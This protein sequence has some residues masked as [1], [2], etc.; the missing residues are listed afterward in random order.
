MM[1]GTSRAFALLRRCLALLPLLV[2]A[3]LLCVA[4]VEAE[5]PAVPAPSLPP[6]LS[7]E[8]PPGWDLLPGLSAKIAETS[9]QTAY[10]GEEP[11]SGGAMAYGRANRGALYFTWVDGQSAHPSPESA[12]RG[13]F[14]GV[15]ESPFLATSDAG[16]TQ[17]VLYRER[18]FDGV[19]ELNF[20]WAHMNNDTVNVV[21][22]LGWKSDDGRVHLAIA[23]CVLHNES[24]GEFR[25]LCEAALASL[26]LTKEVKH[27]PL[28]S[29]AAPKLIGK[30]GAE[31]MKVPK[32]QS[33]E[34][35]SSPSIN[36]APAQMGEVLYRGP[37][38]ATSQDKSN[39][40]L[41]GIGVL[42]LAAAFWLTTRSKPGDSSVASE[43]EHG[44]AEDTSANAE[45]AGADEDTGEDDHEDE[46]KADQEKAE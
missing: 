18:N 11:A 2:I 30:L 43:G 39:R 1:R 25:P 46:Q 6:Q 5:Q 7:L 9:A 35:P 8:A 13:A 16:S 10:F 23:E 32:L 31:D 40:V 34:S 4:A 44:D 17:E 37:P 12:L 3:S 24:V 28:R 27:E 33:G 45:D 26:H 21:R 15:H 42:L 22:A 20:E 29:L 14:D 41:I 38:A 36:S 19:A